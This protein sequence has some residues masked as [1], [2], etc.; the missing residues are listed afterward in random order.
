MKKSTE[1]KINTQDEK[2]MAVTYEIAI[3]LKT[4]K[5]EPAIEE[6]I[7]EIKKQITDLGGEINEVKSA[8]HKILAYPIKHQDSASYVFLKIRIPGAA[9]L[10]IQKYLK[11]RNQVLR[12]LFIKLKIAKIK[13]KKIKIKT[14]KPQTITDQTEKTAKGPKNLIETTIVKP[15][16]IKETKVSIEEL[17]KKLD[18]ILD[19]EI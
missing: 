11:E 3:I 16:P 1:E 8:I 12:F 14:A 7:S 13:I 5:D 17:D 19:A 2:P 6:I 4:A 15:K 10:D 18:Q 9:I